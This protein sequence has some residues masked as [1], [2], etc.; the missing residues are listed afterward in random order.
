MTNASLF[1]SEKSRGHFALCG[2]R[3]RFRV[4]VHDLHARIL[5]L[6]GLDHER[7]A[8]RYAG[9]DFRLTDVARNGVKGIL[10]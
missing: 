9:R 7:L 8:Y 2:C 5:F 1:L 3:K 10:A 6:L 4:R